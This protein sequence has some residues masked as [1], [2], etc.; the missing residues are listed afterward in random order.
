[1]ALTLR[2]HERRL[3]ATQVGSLDWQDT[4]R[5]FDRC[6]EVLAA[7]PEV[8]QLL[9]DLSEA[10]LDMSPAEAAQLAEIV[11]LTFSRKIT[12]AIVSPPQGEAFAL[13]ARYAG[14]LQDKGVRIRACKDRPEA[15][16]FLDTEGRKR[17]HM[18]GP[19]G[20]VIAR[21]A[22]AFQPGKAKRNP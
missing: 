2:V 4:D 18:L 17:S 9:L 19:A 21:W 3:I 22:R 7:R 5:A 13:V 6:E 20:R 15:L 11:T 1:M 16:A 14:T 8:S 12:T 10:R